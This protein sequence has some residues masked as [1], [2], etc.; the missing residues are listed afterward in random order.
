[1]TKTTSFRF[2]Q[3]VR[4]AA[5]GWLVV[6]GALS[7]PALAS[8]REP[9]DKDKSTAQGPQSIVRVYPVADLLVAPED[10]PY[11]G[12]LPQS[13]PFDDA[14][15]VV[16]RAAPSSP[17]APQT[18]AEG[19][20]VAFHRSRAG[21]LVNT[22]KNSI[23]GDWDEE[24]ATCI[25]FDNSLVIRQTMEKHEAIGHLLQALRSNGKVGR[26]VTVEATWLALSPQQLETVR[27]AS[28]E[29]SGTPAALA[30]TV[31]ELSRQA[32]LFH[33]QITCLNRQQVHLATGRRQVVSMGGIPTVGVGAMGYSPTVAVIN[34][35]AVLQV[36]P[37]V[38][39]EGGKAFVDLN[40]TVTQW[41]EPAAAFQVAG[42]VMAGVEEKKLGG[43]LVQTLISVDRADIGTQEWSST[44]SI[45]IG[46][47]AYVGSVSLSNDKASH[48]EV[49]QNSELALVIEVRAE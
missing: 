34:L 36:T 35:G 44:V 17:A 11:R 2:P 15:H 31:Q 21:Q 18:G 49:G 3:T 12:G 16:G 10:Y 45:P 22:I 33:G 19:P 39:V 23:G 9:A 28:E 27:R 4:G 47:P 29:K 13:K 26:S 24:R 42:Q 25:F 14:P 40:S 30:K 7:L 46:R 6:A 37:T 38:S 5:I 1:M 41:K 32:T 48:L 8:G 43:P 20:T